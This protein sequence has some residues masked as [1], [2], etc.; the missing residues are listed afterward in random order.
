MAKNVTIAGAS[1][2]G[3]PAID[4]PQTGGGS[5]RFYDCVGSRTITENKT[6]DVTGLASVTVAIPFVTVYSGS[7]TPASSLG[8][9]GDIYVVV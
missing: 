5:A 2:S 8:Q 6:E 3:V 1:Y 9:N 7:S 4:V